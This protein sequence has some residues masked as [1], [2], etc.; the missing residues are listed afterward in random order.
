[1]ETF[2]YIKVID[3]TQ[4]GIIVDAVIRTVKTEKENKSYLRYL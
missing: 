2:E 3:Y 4:G 1:M